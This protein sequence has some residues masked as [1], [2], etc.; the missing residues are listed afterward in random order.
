MLRRRPRKPTLLGEAFAMK[1]SPSLEEVADVMR[2]HDEIGARRRQLAI[3]LAAGVVLL[4]LV[5]AVIFL[6]L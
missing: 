6:V 2:V 5:T 1:R 3:R 4:A